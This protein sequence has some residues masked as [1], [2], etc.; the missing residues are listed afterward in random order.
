MR[1]PRAE[2]ALVSPFNFRPR[3]G[4]PFAISSFPGIQSRDDPLTGHPSIWRAS[5]SCDK[6]PHPHTLG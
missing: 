4:P 5:S 2:G 3:E 6:D 1:P